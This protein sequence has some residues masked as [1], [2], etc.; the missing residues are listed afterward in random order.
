MGET[1]VEQGGTD[2]ADTTGLRS[3]LSSAAVASMSA[4]ILPGLPVELVGGMGYLAEVFTVGATASSLVGWGIHLAFCALFGAVWATFA[5][6]GRVR[7]HVLTPTTGM[8]TGMFYGVTLWVVNVGLLMP[9]FASHLVGDVGLP[10]PYLLA[11]D[12][13]MALIGHMMWGGILGL[14]YPLVREELPT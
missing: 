13:L 8:A 6:I 10:F 11:F 12:S 7:R 1:L 2:T 9:L 3:E 4:G 5:G 14:G